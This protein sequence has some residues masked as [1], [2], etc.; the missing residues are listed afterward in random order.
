MIDKMIRDLR[1]EAERDEKRR[2][3][4]NVDRTQLKYEIEDLGTDIKK[5]EELLERQD[6]EKEELEAA[7]EDK[8]KEIDETNTTIA[9]LIEDREEAHDEF[10]KALK[11]DTDSINLLQQAIEALTAVYV[12]N[13][14]P[15]GLIE[16]DP[17]PAAFSKGGYQGRKGES[18]G[19]IAILTMIKEDLESE[20]TRSK[21]DEEAAQMEF[22]KQFDD[23]KALKQKQLEARTALKNKMSRKGDEKKNK[24]DELAVVDVPCDWVLETFDTRKEKRTADLVMKKKKLS[25]RKAL[26]KLPFPEEAP[27][28][29]TSVQ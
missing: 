9:E 19:V 17:K 3:E 16:E 27:P 10:E 23:L 12:N 5:L 29:P 22:Q 20:A 25:K 15:L 24:E 7:I 8:Q 21:E 26:F 11:D 2:E 18:G 6:S 4:C 14:I 1:L 28:I 13:K